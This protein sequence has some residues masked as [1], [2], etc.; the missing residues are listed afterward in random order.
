MD[1]DHLHQELR[2]NNCSGVL[3][4]IAIV[5]GSLSRSAQAPRGV[6]LVAD[7]GRCCN[8]GNCHSVY[9]SNNLGESDQLPGDAI[10]VATTSLQTLHCLQSHVLQAA[11]IIHND[12]DLCQALRLNDA[13]THVSFG[14]ALDS[15]CSQLASAGVYINTVLQSTSALLH[16][17]C[18][19]E[20]AALL[21]AI[22]QACKNAG[23]PL[24]PSPP[25][26]PFE[27]F[28]STPYNC[29]PEA[30]TLSC[31]KRQ[32]CQATTVS[33][34]VLGV[35]LVLLLLFLGWKLRDYLVCP[36]CLPETDELSAMEANNLLDVAQIVH[37]ATHEGSPGSRAVPEHAVKK[38]FDHLPSYIAAKLAGYKKAK[39]QKRRRGGSR[40]GTPVRASRAGSPSRGSSTPRGIQMTSHMPRSPEDRQRRKD[41]GKGQKLWDDDTSLDNSMHRSDA[42]DEALIGVEPDQLD[43]ALMQTDDL[44]PH[45]HASSASLPLTE[46]YSIASC[47]YPPLDMSNVQQYGDGVLLSADVS[48]QNLARSSD[49][50]DEMRDA[51]PSS[52]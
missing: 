29:P 52:V 17:L 15:M 21:A 14:T 34:T 37:S 32:D 5:W 4:D 12:S 11:V 2:A 3:L 50:V 20:A 38:G 13:D 45:S 24:P 36:C 6:A 49:D 7:T 47:S 30:N 39:Q 35:F 51:E 43:P 46:Q 22:P 18:K 48:D 26:T 8:Q 42:S 27:Q 10:K 41:K 23:H 28:V 16:A 25:N 9:T 31:C 40:A 44:S 19:P 1:S 33:V